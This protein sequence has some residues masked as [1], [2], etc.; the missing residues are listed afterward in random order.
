[1]RSG[2]YEGEDPQGRSTLD[3]TALDREGGHGRAGMGEDFGVP[4]FRIEGDGPAS[5]GGGRFTGTFHLGRVFKSDHICHDTRVHRSRPSKRDDRV[6]EVPTRA[7][8]ATATPVDSEGHVLKTRV[9]L[10]AFLD[11]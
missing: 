1:M 5:R 6:R 11:R 3:G 2:G 7:E 9:R 8:V 4:R 10:G